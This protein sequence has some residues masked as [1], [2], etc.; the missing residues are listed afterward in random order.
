MSWVKAIPGSGEDVFDED[1]DDINLQSKEWKFNM[2]RRIKD[3]FVD[4]I[5][6]GE[7][8]ALSVGFK[9]GYQEG[10]A[11][12]AAVGRL[13]GIVSAISCWFQ[14]HH[15]GSPVPAS[16]TDLLQRIVQH[17]EAIM[18]G[19]QRALENPPPSVS[20]ASESM[21]DLEIKQEDQDCQ[22]G[23]CNE[24]N[25]CR[26][27]GKMDTDAPRQP[28]S[29]CSSSSDCCFNTGETLNE[30]LQR[31]VDVVVE[32]GLPQELIQHLQQLRGTE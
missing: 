9:Q 11:K 19:I 27:G 12:T 16:L 3:G 31:S 25:C 18:S 13:K 21:E 17:E 7:D 20:D 8:A 24:G 15:P 32:L 26:G 5:D 23:G 10:A 6:A 14:T 2:K 4:G 30:L 22:G 29:R 1:A 28:Q